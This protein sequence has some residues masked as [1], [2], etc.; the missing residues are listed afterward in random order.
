M[1]PIQAQKHSIRAWAI[2]DRPREKLLSKTPIALSN[3]ELIAILINDGNQGKSAVDLGKEI[4]S[5]G[6]NSLEAL[7]RLGVK[8]LMKI[9]GIGAAKAVRIAAALE[10]GRRRQAGKNPEKTPVK[11]SQDIGGYLQALYKDLL[12][13]EFGV[14]YLNKANKI[15]CIEIVSKGGVTGTI[16]DPRVILKR[17]LEENATSLI[18]F[19]NH[20]SGNLEPS[21]SDKEITTKINRAATYLDIR[22]LD[23]IIVSREGYYSFAD[24]G[25]IKL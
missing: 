11:G 22:V 15:N 1:K 6:G 4:M 9:K 17:A 7:G 12:H 23:H 16:A 5:L 3:S 25:L 13:E 20:P 10:L 21:L 24:R 19:H 14:I 8:D 18:L 2:D